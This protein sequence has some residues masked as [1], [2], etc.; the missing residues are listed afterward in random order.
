VV[1]K[2]DPNFQY[3]QGHFCWT[4]LN[5]AEEAKQCL[6]YAG[7]KGH[8]EA[9]YLL[10]QIYE[11]EQAY[12]S[13]AKW[14]RLAARQGQHATAQY[15]LAHLYLRG[16][17]VKREPV[18]AL[19]WLRAAAEGRNVAA[20]YEAAMM[21]QAQNVVEAYAWLRLAKARKSAEAA[22]A[23]GSLRPSLTPEQVAEA[24]VVAA[25]LRT[26]LRKPAKRIP[27]PQQGMTYYVGAQEVW[28]SVCEWSVEYSVQPWSDGR[29][30]LHVTGEEGG[31]L[32]EGPLYP[33]ALLE[34][35]EEQ[36]LDPGEFLAQLRARD[37]PVL[38]VLAREIEQAMT[39]AEE[40]S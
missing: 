32:R 33:E 15:R 9:Q 4:F 1:T 39:A 40:E 7:R 6:T 26:Q 19:R 36:G 27:K 28:G 16:L 10:G 17:G 12:R 22:A 18:V 31:N 38:N 13:A 5:N 29:W 24:K 35:M 8:T 23:A 37:V 34:V 2:H 30:M 21:L 25:K 11:Q 20:M 14:F 3:I